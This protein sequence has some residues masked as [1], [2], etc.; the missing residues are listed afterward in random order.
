MLQQLVSTSHN[1]TKHMQ[2][3]G[4]CSDAFLANSLLNIQ[5]MHTCWPL[6]FHLKS[7]SS[8]MFQHMATA[9]IQSDVPDKDDADFD[10]STRGQFLY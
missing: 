2:H 7:I 6:W 4:K 1:C 9:P 3:F 5:L 8:R 10:D